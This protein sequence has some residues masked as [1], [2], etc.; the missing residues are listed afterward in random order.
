MEGVV[1][2]TSKQTSV[3]RTL[4]TDELG[5]ALPGAAVYLLPKAPVPPSEIRTAV[6]DSQ[7]H[8]SLEDSGSGVYV[9]MAL[10]D[11]FDPEWHSVLL[12]QGCSG[13]VKI[14]LRVA[15]GPK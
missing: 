10:M 13:S 6:S 14:V 4:V 3:V 2:D 12:E 5:V 8:A 1:C 15:T 7:G 11:G 9:V